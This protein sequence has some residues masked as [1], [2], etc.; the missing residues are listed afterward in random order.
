MAVERGSRNGK[1]ER[2]W[3]RNGKKKEKR[4]KKENGKKKEKREENTQRTRPATT[5]WGSICSFSMDC[6]GKERCGEYQACMM[7]T[8]HAWGV[9]SMHGKYQAYMGKVWGDRRVGR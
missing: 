9:P 1:S 4:R 3:V 7:S 5:P 2:R 6:E 8:K